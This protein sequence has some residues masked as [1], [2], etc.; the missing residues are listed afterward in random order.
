VAPHL[1]LVLSQAVDGSET[2]ARLPE[3]RLSD[4]VL[5]S[6]IAA[7]AL[8]IIVT[9]L[10]AAA[11][12]LVPLAVAGLVAVTS[13]PLVAGLER[14]RMPTWLAVIATLVV[15]LLTVLGP[16]VVVLNAATTFVAVAPD[17]AARLNAMSAAWFEWLYE[18]GIDT[19][20]LAGVV[21]WNAALNLAGGLVVNA[22]FVLSN[23]VLVLFLVGFILMEAANLPHALSRVLVVDQNGTDRIHRAARDVQRYL[24]VKTVISLATGVILGLWTAALGVDFAVLWGLLAFLLNYI[25]NFGSI[26]AGLPP[27]LL[28]LVQV[29]PGRAAAVM[30]G[31]LTVNMVL[32]NVLEPYVMGRRL[33]LSPLVVVLSL[34]FWGWVWGSVGLVVAVPITMIIRIF[35]EQSPEWRW[36][37]VLI[38]GGE[39]SFVVRSSRPQSTAAD[40]EAA[41]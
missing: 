12:L 10:R 4:S 3:Q 20:P 1:T 32:G 14:H 35:L 31:F 24:R 22:A 41:D 26:L 21:N 29:G 13:Y 33:Q 25:P 27:V 38:A 7:A 8:V 37:A 34:V 30:A 15:M 18:R 6:L 11:T 19:S 2:E 28:A 36:V 40:G 16:G 17:Y 5:R 39:T 9:G 23:A